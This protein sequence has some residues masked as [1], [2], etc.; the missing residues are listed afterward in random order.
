M[1]I[2]A[3]QDWE[4]DF[5]AKL[6]EDLYEIEIWYGNVD[7]LVW[8]PSQSKGFHLKSYYNILKEG[9]EGEQ[10]FCRKA[11]RKIVSHQGGLSIHG[12]VSGRILIVENLSKR[13]RIITEWCFMRKIHGRII[14][15][16]CATMAMI[17]CLFGAS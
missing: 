2:R 4:V 16:C 13:A 3:V 1:F 9:G 7:K 12:V 6:L 11:F 10:V 8:F 15:L 14:Y 5:L 17:F